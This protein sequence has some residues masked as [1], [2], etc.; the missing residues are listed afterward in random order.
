MVEGKY[1]LVESLAAKVA[2]DPALQQQLRDN[3]VGTLQNLAGSPLQTDPWIYRIVVAALGAAVLIAII[4][5]A[6]LAGLAKTVPEGVIAIG[7]AAAGALAGLLA[8]SPV[9]Q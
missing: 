8:P 9:R 7:S 5:A 3:P 4:A 1:A 2:A 6:T